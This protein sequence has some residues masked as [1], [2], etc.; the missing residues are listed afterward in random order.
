M[1]MR[2]SDQIAVEE[3]LAGKG[4]YQD[5]DEK[6]IVGHNGAI[7]AVPKEV[8]EDL[9]AFDT[10]YWG[11]AI[12]NGRG[13]APL[14]LLSPGVLCDPQVR[15]RF[16]PGQRRYN[17]V[18][19]E[20]V[21]D[22]LMDRVIVLAGGEHL[23]R[24]MPRSH[25][26]R[27]YFDDD[28][29]R[30]AVSR[31]QEKLPS[32]SLLKTLP[33]EEENRGMDEYLGTLVN[34]LFPEN[35][36][37][38]T[39]V[40]FLTGEP[41]L[42]FSIAIRSAYLK[43][44]YNNDAVEVEESGNAERISMECL[45]PFVGGT[46]MKEPVTNKRLHNREQHYAFC[47]PLFHQS[48]EMYIGGADSYRL[49]EMW[50]N[51]QSGNN[52]VDF[53]NYLAHFR[54]TYSVDNKSAT[55]LELHGFIEMQATL[56]VLNYFVL[57]DIDVGSNRLLIALLKTAQYI[58]PEAQSAW[59]KCD[60]AGKYPNLNQSRLPVD[61]KVVQRI[62][63]QCGTVL[64]RMVNPMAVKTYREDL[65]GR[66]AEGCTEEPTSRFGKNEYLQAQVIGEKRY[67]W[68]HTVRANKLASLTA[69]ELE[70][71]Y[72]AYSDWIM[73]YSML[74]DVTS[75]VHVRGFRP[76][77]KKDNGGKDDKKK[78]VLIEPYSWLTMCEGIT[79]TVLDTL[80]MGLN[81]DYRLVKAE[82]LNGALLCIRDDLWDTSLGY[83]QPNGSRRKITDDC[84]E[85]GIAFYQ[86][87]G[88]HGCPCY[89]LFKITQ[90]IA[91]SNAPVVPTDC[92]HAVPTKKS[93]V[94]SDAV[95]K[96]VNGTLRMRED[97]GR[98]GDF[99]IKDNNRPEGFVEDD[100]VKE[101]K[102]TSIYQT[103]R[104]ISMIT[105][106][107][108]GTVSLFDE[109]D[110]D[111]LRIDNRL[112]HA[113]G[114]TVGYIPFDERSL[115]RG[116]ITKV[117]GLE[118]TISIPG[119]FQG[120]PSV[121]LE[122]ASDSSK[123][124]ET[125]DE[126]EEEDLYLVGGSSTRSNSGVVCGEKRKHKGGADGRQKKQKK[127]SRGV[128]W[129]ARAY[130]VQM[131]D[132]N[133]V[134]VERKQINARYQKILKSELV[135]FAEELTKIFG[136]KH[137]ETLYEA[138]NG[139]GVDVGMMYDKVANNIASMLHYKTTD[140]LLTAVKESI[141]PVTVG[142][143]RK[144]LA[145]LDPTSVQ[146]TIAKANERALMCYY[147]FFYGH[148]ATLNTGAT[149][150]LENGAV[151]GP[152]IA[153]MDCQSGFV[154]PMVDEDGVVRVQS[155]TGYGVETIDT[156]LVSP[157]LQLVSPI[158]VNVK[159][160]TIL[161]GSKQ[162]NMEFWNTKGDGMASRGPRAQKKEK[163]INVCRQKNHID[164]YR[165]YVPFPLYN[166]YGVKEPSVVAEALIRTQ[167]LYQMV[168]KKQ[169]EI[170]VLHDPDA[171]DDL[172][173]YLGSTEVNEVTT[174]WREMMQRYIVKTIALYKDMR[175][176]IPTAIGQTQMLM[177][178]T[179]DVSTA[180]KIGEVLWAHW[181]GHE[182]TSTLVFPTDDILPV[183]VLE[184]VFQRYPICKAILHG[185][186]AM[187]EVYGVKSTFWR[188]IE[189]ER[190]IDLVNNMVCGII[191]PVFSFDK[192]MMTLNERIMKG[193]DVA[194]IKGI[195]PVCKIVVNYSGCSVTHG[196]A[197]GR[198][199]TV[200]MCGQIGM[201][202]VNMNGGGT[203]T[204]GYRV[205]LD[206]S[207]HPN[208]NIRQTLG[209]GVQQYPDTT[210]VMAF[211]E[212]RRKAYAP[213]QK[214]VDIDVVLRSHRSFENFMTMKNAAEILLDHI[215]E[216]FGLTSNDD[217][218][219]KTWR[220]ADPDGENVDK[221]MSMFADTYCDNMYKGDTGMGI[222][223]K[224]FTPTVFPRL[225]DRYYN[226]DLIS[227]GDNEEDEE[228]Q[229][230]IDKEELIAKLFGQSESGE[231]SGEDDDCIDSDED[232]DAD[233]MTYY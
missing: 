51:G 225:F 167:S 19:L 147:M 223:K 181:E 33:H 219:C 207:F 113:M 131:L 233:D 96:S 27:H 210:H 122:P 68:N 104:S 129:A 141:A 214:D 38:Q 197:L 183:G 32:N 67:P 100:A 169:D 136:V 35:V 80:L 228:S 54:S 48:N 142:I 109:R 156:Q 1:G 229:G 75:A 17:S 224:I 82:V 182:K 103:Q 93:Y 79:F 144:M 160:D 178:D 204:V 158:R 70:P 25:S 159:T 203:H 146:S 105:S 171:V 45:L 209:L 46:V 12:H 143:K 73:Q 71:G 40:I 221:F 174:L 72:A 15:L 6:Q 58:L 44:T 127:G 117:P 98:Y 85:C 230:K 30:E 184:K 8:Y 133:R 198:N 65:P 192:D 193:D 130:A 74:S 26:E 57:D 86:E 99:A 118:G 116:A 97:T 88:G 120:S 125:L 231:I 188:N 186:S 11:I 123:L 95:L 87:Y 84:P 132:W 152:T 56:L 21:D 208:S 121:T 155:G 135:P 41:V 47:R 91:G 81:L 92:L 126:L 22:K 185:V 53:T 77:N 108:Y 154:L 55:R 163:E 42:M 212:Y 150:I 161:K 168:T 89:G 180:N 37:P 218:G 173:R 63:P 200:A 217:S 31:L 62:I 78:S 20:S 232:D 7:Y 165:N 102:T 187:S 134:T 199:G 148:N 111:G 110:P 23:I 195:K 24:N 76:I 39:H 137:K 151:I 206:N 124:E 149:S 94:R 43:S 222:L 213:R 90:I 227:T 220:M 194:E 59:F 215:A 18:A 83:L 4:I 60:F 52:G 107:L 16:T 10:A 196:D 119:F 61:S 2:S 64:R 175:E 157:T 9:S 216:P 28:L 139:L 179:I 205:T 34:K 36:T 191:K 145:W 189:G 202:A 106:K 166:T 69:E 66:S 13:T 29:L 201:K 114:K 112:S 153:K 14:Q 5:A 177:N 190:D 162:M 164:V 211:Y 176:L 226:S 128:M 172:A 3:I 170:D 101:G 49:L 50:V 140:E 138:L 115:L